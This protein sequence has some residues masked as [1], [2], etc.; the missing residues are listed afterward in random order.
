MNKTEELALN[1]LVNSYGYDRNSIIFQHSTSPDFI[2]PDGM[3]VEV[4]N[5]K[6]YTLNIAL[7]QW[8]NINNV[9]FCVIAIFKG[10]SVPEALI[11]VQALKPPCRLGKYRITILPDPL[12]KYHRHLNLLSRLKGKGLNPQDFWVEYR[13]QKELENV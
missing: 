4:K 2:L 5:L 10:K 9:K 1:W 6:G 13:K 3:A 12:E 8:E 11:P 7:S